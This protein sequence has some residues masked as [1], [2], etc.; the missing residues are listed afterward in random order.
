M[1]Q[2]AHLLRELIRR[3]CTALLGLCEMMLSPRQDLRINS[4]DSH[5]ERRGGSLELTALLFAVIP[6]VAILPILLYIG[7]V[8]G[9]QAFQATPARH[10]PAIVLALLP[11]IA[12]WAQPRSTARS[13]PPAPRPTRSAWRSS[14]PP[15]VVY[16]GMALLGGGAMLAGLIFGAI[17][18]LYRR[19]QIRLGSPL[20][21]G[22]RR[23][24]VFRLHPRHRP[25]H[26][27]LG[28]VALGYLF[29]ATVCFALSRQEHP[30]PVLLVGETEAE[31]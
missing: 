18:G 16:H 10:A 5:S 9:G 2:R 29:I 3:S 8:I 6:L 14:A 24:V 19:P 1:A 22:R 7:R 26:R 31:D 12:A 15:A 23:A 13:A 30:A 4:L 27:R 21:R 20:R 28:P 11:N 25:R 17:A